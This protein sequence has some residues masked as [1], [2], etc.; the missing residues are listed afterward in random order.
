MI[1]N[2]SLDREVGNNFQIHYIKQYL[3]KARFGLIT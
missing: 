3:C 1:M 2:K